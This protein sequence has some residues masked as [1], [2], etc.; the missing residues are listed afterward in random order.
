[1]RVE[2]IKAWIFPL[3]KS[4]IEVQVYTKQQDAPPSLPPRIDALSSPA[5]ER[6]A[7]ADL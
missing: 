6:N 4:T 1:M 3:G 5:H 7:N 2:Y